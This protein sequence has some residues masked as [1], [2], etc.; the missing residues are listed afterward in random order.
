MTL[1]RLLALIPLLAVFPPL[2]LPPVLAARELALPVDE[3]LEALL[4]AHDADGDRKI[5]VKDGAPRPFKARLS[6][7]G[8]LELSGHYRLSVLLQE[9]KLAEER[10]QKELKAP[11]ALL[12]ENPVDRTSRLIRELFWPS[13][14]RRVDAESLRTLG[15]EKAGPASERWIYVPAADALAKEHFQAAAKQDPALKLRVEVLP[16]EITAAYVRGLDGRHGLLPL[17]LKEEGG[18]VRG[19]PFVVPGG[20]FNEMY[21]WDCYFIALGLLED[22]YW[23]LARSMVDNHVYQVRHYGRVLNANRSYYLTRSQPPLLTSMALAVYE[24]SPKAPAD[25]AWLQKALEAAIAEYDR[26]WQA[27]PRY[28]PEH[29][30]SR[31]YDDG[32][33]PCPEVD[34]KEYEAVVGPYARAAG[35]PIGRYLEE[36]AR[37]RRREPALDA[38]FLHDRAV[39]ESGHDTT[40]R[41]DLRT[42]DF[43][44]VD[45]NSLLYKIESDL[46]AAIELEFGGAFTDASGRRQDA[47]LW[48]WR[49]ALRWE[50]I[51]RL[52]WDEEKGLYF[53]YD[54]KNGRRSGYVSAT[55][56]YPLW[57]GAADDPKARRVAAAALPELERLGGLAAT[58]ES[59]RG[60]LSPTRPERQ[61]DYPFGWAP[62]QMIAWQGLRRHGMDA[63]A[64]RLAYRWLWAIAVNARDYNGTVA[65]K[66]DVVKASH[67]VFAEYG[68]VGT[69]FDY[70]TKEGFGWMNASFQVGLKLLTPEQRKALRALTPPSP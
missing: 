58:S 55:T 65:E 5:T 46:A 44:T 54:M 23:D 29:G 22:G 50:R 27:P 3:T 26:V 63:D 57:A 49:A 21:G 32:A 68:N 33:G 24:R 43:L 47:A 18:R 36:Y 53:D 60:P 51:E 62:H 16:K 12:E 25:K 31:Y 45:L 1:P 11:A 67:E 61:W 34:P 52:F 6:H 59:S 8:E 15:D 14:T 19:V 40:Y 20:R 7:G 2:A 56:F 39:R 35:L 17:A 38:F 9:L 41:F 30:L 4:R 13:L 42:A 28:V 64:R 70:I 66:L 10:G 37:G 69:K 48:R